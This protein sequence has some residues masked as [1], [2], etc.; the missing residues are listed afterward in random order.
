M[1]STALF[2]GRFQPFHLG[3]LSVIQQILTE[4]NHLIIGIGSSQY[5]KTPDN[6]YSF[7]ERATMI[8]AALNEADI[9]QDHYQII[10]IP[11]IHD[12]TNWTSHV[13]QLTP[14]FDLIYTGSPIV[15][16]LFEIDGQTPI[17]P[18]IFKHTINATE[19]RELM[20]TGGE[21]KHLVPRSCIDFL[22]KIAL[23][24]PLSRI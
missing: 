8:R 6:P 7:N 20:A 19:I 21:W 10:A 2:I 4:N 17:R 3:H 24:K 1:N 16:K 13:R 12:E 18:V 9:P 5:S 15:K 14:H 11:D 22:S 23:N